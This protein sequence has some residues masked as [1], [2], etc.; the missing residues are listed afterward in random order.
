MHSSIAKIW[1]IATLSF[2]LTPAHAGTPRKMSPARLDTYNATQFS[3][4]EEVRDHRAPTRAQIT[5]IPQNFG[6]SQCAPASVYT[7][8]GR[9]QGDY[10][11]FVRKLHENGWLQ[12]GGGVRLIN[13][14]SMMAGMGHP[15]HFVSLLP[16]TNSVDELLER[17]STALDEGRAVFLSVEV[18]AIY[19]AAWGNTNNLSE[20]AR[21]E[22]EAAPGHVIRVTA[23]KRD[24]RGFVEKFGIW[25]VNTFDMPRTSFTKDGTVLWYNELRRALLS[26]TSY[27]TAL[28]R[29]AFITDDVVYG[30]AP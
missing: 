16:V 10:L 4:Y 29:G 5:S 22:L 28:N 17:V 14:P 23:V 8:A 21:K 7:L 27:T 26:N 6:G 24:S 15:V 12:E 11:S 9:E 13:F 18:L 30:T 20:Q 3:R 19:K 25:D 2:L 1:V